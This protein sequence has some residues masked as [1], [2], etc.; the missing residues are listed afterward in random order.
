MHATSDV[1]IGGEVSMQ[2]AHLF[3]R[4]TTLGI[5]MLTLLAACWRS[6]PP[7]PPPPIVESPPPARTVAPP[8]RPPSVM[9]LFER[10]ADDMCNC[11]D[12]ACAQG[13][14]DEMVRWSQEQAKSQTAP[15]DLTDEEQ[16]RAVEIGERM[17]NC[18]QKAMMPAAGSATP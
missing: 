15:P 4:V 14:S 1:R 2:R 12:M 11:S 8:P 6:S 13:V 17:G 9:E 7:P 10:F 16:K 5:V 3:A 18:M